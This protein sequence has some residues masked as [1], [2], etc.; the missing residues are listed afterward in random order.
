MRPSA[1]AATGRPHYLM[2]FRP[3]DYTRDGMW[4]R[5]T[6]IPREVRKAGA[7]TMDLLFAVWEFEA[8]HELGGPLS[9]RGLTVRGLSRVTPGRGMHAPREMTFHIA[10]NSQA[11]HIGNAGNGGA[12]VMR[13]G[14]RLQCCG[15]PVAVTPAFRWACTGDAA[16]QPLQPLEW[17]VAWSGIITILSAARAREVDLLAR[18]GVR[19]PLVLPPRF[20]RQAHRAADLVHHLDSLA[21]WC[22][23]SEA[24]LLAW[25]AASQDIEV[26]RM[27]P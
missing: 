25:L 23:D 7:Q 11:C 22:G 8:R 6:F 20:A 4:G 9:E 13:D 12:L 27:I 5:A 19:P 18:P 3:E 1:R 24:A 10:G 16:R 2:R 15:R 14:F 21:E 17:L 26:P